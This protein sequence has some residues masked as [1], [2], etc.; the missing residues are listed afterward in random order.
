M[1]SLAP[2]PDIGVNVGGDD[3]MNMVASNIDGMQFPFA[4]HAMAADGRL[5]DLPL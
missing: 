5:D 2:S 4:N 1:L 3:D